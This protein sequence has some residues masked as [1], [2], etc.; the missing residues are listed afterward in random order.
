MINTRQRIPAIAGKIKYILN[1]LSRSISERKIPV[2]KELSPTPN[3]KVAIISED[4]NA[5]WS[6]KCLIDRS[7]HRGK[8]AEQE[9]PA[10]AKKK[11][12]EIAE[13]VN[14]ISRKIIIIIGG[15]RIQIRSLAT[16]RRSKEKIIR[17][18]TIEIQK[19]ESASEAE[20]KSIFFCS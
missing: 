11:I 2:I 6:G 15:I 10:N 19:A 8:N 4:T 1:R 20:A 3:S 12:P 13:L 7:I 5:P 16:F 17:P 18:M 14:G 9:R